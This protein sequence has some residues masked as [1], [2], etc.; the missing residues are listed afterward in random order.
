MIW[1]SIVKM[2]AVLLGVLGFILL[3]AYAARRFGLGNQRRHEDDSG[4]EIVGTRSLGPRRQIIVLKVGGSIL[5]VGASDKTLSPLMEIRDAAE[6][7]KVMKG[8][9]KSP[10]LSFRKIL[11][12][13]QSS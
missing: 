11:A 6:Q 10:A 5:L 3:L 7:E 4:V 12:K 9:E 1:L 8:F 13:A 2:I